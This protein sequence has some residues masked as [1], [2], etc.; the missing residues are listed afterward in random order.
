M[1]ECGNEHI[2]ALKLHGIEFLDL[3]GDTAVVKPLLPLG[4]GFDAAQVN[5]L[6]V[7]VLEFVHD[8]WTHLHDI[9]DEVITHPFLDV[10]GIAGTRQLQLDTPHVLLELSHLV[11]GF[12][13]RLDGTGYVCPFLVTQQRK[14][15][16]YQRPQLDLRLI[17]QGISLEQQK[18]LVL[19]VEFH[20]P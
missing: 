15:G 1:R 8:V 10:F 18:Q 16:T 20:Q 11:Q 3:A 4:V 7:L 17:A 6:G 14:H 2:A 12:D 9:G 13:T 5:D 19:I